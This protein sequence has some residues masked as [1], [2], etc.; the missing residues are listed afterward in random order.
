M[1]LTQ[2]FG[3]ILVFALFA[4]GISNCAPPAPPSPSN[5][6]IEATVPPSLTPAPIGTLAASTP[7]PCSIDPSKGGTCHFVSGV[8]ENPKFVDVRIIVPH[9]LDDS[10]ARGLLNFT[11]SIP[12]VALPPPPGLKY[13]RDIITLNVSDK[14]GKVTFFDPAI[15]IIV[16]ASTDDLQKAKGNYNL[17]LLHHDG[18]A[19]NRTPMLISAATT[20]FDISLPAFPNGRTADSSQYQGLIGNLGDPDDGIGGD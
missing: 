12:L 9:Q 16:R 15:T 11:S 3:W 14:T 18:K 20:I 2:R 4:L 19:W 6:K 10:P 7:T 17:F 13:F 5:P 1:K 8:P